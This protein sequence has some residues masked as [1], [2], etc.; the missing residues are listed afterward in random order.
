MGTLPGAPKL[1]ALRSGDRVAITIDTNDPP[2]HVLSIRGQA[3]VSEI[4]GVVEEYAKAAVRYI[5]KE[6]GEGYVGSL[7]PEI[8]M[9]RI[10]VRPDEVVILDFETRFPSAV[11]SLKLT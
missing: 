11:S 6:Q 4:E 7:P 3:D 5:G 10:A 1:K 8:K 2:H 9:G